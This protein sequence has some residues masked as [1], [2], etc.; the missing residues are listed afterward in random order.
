MNAPVYTLRFPG[1]PH[2]LRAEITFYSSAHV[3]LGIVDDN[4]DQIQAPAVAIF[5]N[6]EDP[7]DK[8]WLVQSMK[9]GKAW[10][11]SMGRR[12]DA[13]HAA[14]GL[15]IHHT[16][17]G[18]VELVDV[19]AWLERQLI[20]PEPSLCPH[21]RANCWECSAGPDSRILPASARLN[22]NLAALTA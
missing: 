21:G 9:G 2:N 17:L 22:H 15:L 1:Y 4:P 12:A 13:I 5:H 19:T 10:E 11:A 7:D 3:E 18:A 6:T 20:Q 14:V 16:G 8:R